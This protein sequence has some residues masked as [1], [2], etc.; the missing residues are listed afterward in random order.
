MQAFF[1]SYLG[2]VT[3]FSFII[4]MIEE[5]E[6]CSDMMKKYFDKEFLI[7]KKGEKDFENSTK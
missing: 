3:V 6:Y 7:T 2:E 5:S 1:K 4:S